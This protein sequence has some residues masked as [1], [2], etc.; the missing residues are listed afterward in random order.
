MHTMQAY[1]CTLIPFEQDNKSPLFFAENRETLFSTTPLLWEG[2][3][4]STS[5]STHMVSQVQLT[6][7]VQLNVLSLVQLMTTIA[8]ELVTL[9]PVELVAPCNG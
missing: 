6:L 9:P 3:T 1:A 5:S 4:S 2:C 7:Q 8:V